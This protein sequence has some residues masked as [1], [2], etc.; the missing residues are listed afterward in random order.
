VITTHY[1][2]D[3]MVERKLTTHSYHDGGGENLH[4]Q[5]VG[6]TTA[7]EEKRPYK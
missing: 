1:H 3:D 6:M 4:D 7:V 2:H 5:G